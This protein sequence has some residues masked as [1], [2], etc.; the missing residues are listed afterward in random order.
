MNVP[1]LRFAAFLFTLSIAGTAAAT[2]T[3]DFSTIAPA[4]DL[5]S[6]SFV[7]GGTG[8]TVQGFYFDDLSENWVTGGANLYVRNQTNDHGLGVCSPADRG[9]G[10]ASGNNCP[11]PNGGGDWNELDNEDAAE[12]IRLELP[13]GYEWVS[14]QLSSLDTNSN[15]VS[16]FGR[17]STSPDGDPE[18]LGVT[19]WEFQG[20]VDPIEAIFLIPASAATARYLF[21]E[22]IDWGA[23]ATNPD[24]ND[25]LVYQ[26]T[27]DRRQVPEPGTLALFGLGLLAIGRARRKR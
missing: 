23:T 17:L 11:G 16:E 25:F 14:V 8:L 27:I 6:S 10:G 3:I 4:G 20:G 22:P 1:G 24:N 2:T 19:L 13:A 7:D 21:F 12:L 15:T 9:Q 26:A 18:N 5:G